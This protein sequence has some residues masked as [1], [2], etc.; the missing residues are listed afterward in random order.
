MQEQLDEVT[1]FTTRSSP[2]LKTPKPAAVS[3]KD[4]RGRTLPGGRYLLPMGAHIVV[5]EG[6]MVH[7]GDVI[8]RFP[9][10]TKTKD[11]TGGLPRVAELFEA[12]K[13][14]EYAIISEITGAVSFG[15]DTKGKRK[16]IITP[17][18]GEPKEYSIPRANTSASRKGRRSGPANRS[19]TA[20]PTRTTSSRSWAWKT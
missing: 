12:R 14:K 3:I 1:G 10:T 8:A 13:P 5:A 7:Q 4:D 18:V 16:V 6:D 11:I 19:W 15:K 17:E 2:N 9:G 20:P